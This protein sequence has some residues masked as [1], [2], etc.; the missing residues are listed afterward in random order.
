M[1]YAIYRVKKYIRN[2]YYQL[3]GINTTS[4]WIPMHTAFIM[5]K[6]RTE[7][8]RRSILQIVKPSNVVLD[9]GAGSGILSLFA[10]QAGA[11]RVYAIERNP[12]IKIA[13]KMAIQNGFEDRI[14]FINEDSRFTNLPEKVDV[15][16]S[17]TIGSFGLEEN[18][19]QI[20]SDAKRRFLKPDGLFVPKGLKFFTAPVYLKESENTD[21][22]NIFANKPWAL[23]FSPI[24]KNI[25]NHVI[26]ILIT[27][28]SNFE[29]LSKP[30]ESG[31]IDFK[32]SKTDSFT[33]KSNIKIQKNGILNGIISYFHIHFTDDIILSPEKAGQTSW[34][35]WCVFAFFP[36][37][38]PKNVK[39]GD[40]FE[41]TVSYTD[42]TG[43][44]V[45]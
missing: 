14:I 40:T 39:A 16:I 45:I 27:Q 20:L 13:K 30:Q 12:I 15:I 41:T 43:W 2:I 5:D 6:T 4:E 3:K 38:N 37:T 36:F 35:S 11:K 28:L 34:S 7:T 10:C 18:I 26:Y 44:Q 1:N 23:D 8:L 25:K 21:L 24:I 33:S 29:F 32:Q 17:E 9:V 42:K 22:I 19:L 31:F